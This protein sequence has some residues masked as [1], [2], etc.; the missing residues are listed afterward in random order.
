VA[1]AV[2]IYGAYESVL[3][4]M[5]VLF[6]GKKKTCEHPMLHYTVWGGATI[7]FLHG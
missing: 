3:A 7:C 1:P 4:G 5:F 2:G 6:L